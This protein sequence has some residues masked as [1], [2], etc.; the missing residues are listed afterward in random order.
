MI[1][2]KE[3][4]QYYNKKIIENKN[5]EKSFEIIKGT[6]PILL[7]APHCVEH[8]RNGKNLRA[9]GETGAIVQILANL[10][11][12]WCI[13]KVNNEQDDANY[14]LEG[15]TYKQEII[16]LIKKHHIKALLDFHG[17][18]NK[19]EF[20]IEIGTD[21]G[22]NLC[23]KEELM[24]TLIKC[25]QKNGIQNIQVNKKFKASSI[26]TISKTIA[27]TTKIPCIQLEIVGKYRYH[28]QIEGVEKL[29]NAVQ[30]WIKEINRNN[31]EG[32]NVEEYPRI[33]S[34]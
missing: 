5:S 7:S 13:Y 23:G 4:I 14:D 20:D 21:D 28:E 30:E 8:F 34:Y 16:K 26:H 6:I 3:Q 12:C 17:A 25:F 10:T 18:D 1:E 33:R 15:N 32:D 29:I 9:E 24:E 2:L 22:N 11:N 31:Y 27:E 19:N